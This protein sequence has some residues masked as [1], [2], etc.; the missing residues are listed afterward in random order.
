MKTIS[1]ELSVQDAEALERIAA[2]IR[3]AVDAEPFPCHEMI[4]PL[5]A[6]KKIV[7]RWDDLTVERVHLDSN[8]VLEI[9]L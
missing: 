9:R 4:A 3:K 8:T 6:I 5:T 2:E 7:V 1:I